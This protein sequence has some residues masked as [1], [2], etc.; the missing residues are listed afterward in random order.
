MSTLTEEQLRKVIESRLD[1]ITTAGRCNSSYIDHTDGLFRGLLWALTGK[2][3]GTYV[4]RDILALC[5]LAGIF[6]LF[7]KDTGLVHYGYS[8]HTPG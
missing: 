6:A 4:T 2:D 5:E 3:P 8:E 1:V 7:D